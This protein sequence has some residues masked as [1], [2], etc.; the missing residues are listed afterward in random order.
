MITKQ[1][2]R[3]FPTL[4]PIPEYDETR[5][6][7]DLFL[8]LETTIDDMLYDYYSTPDIYPHYSSFLDLFQWLVDHQTTTL[9]NARLD[10][11]K[12]RG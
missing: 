3:F 6:W 12:S 2:R 7:V 8:S 11:D 9:L 1:S 5:L 10:G 4:A